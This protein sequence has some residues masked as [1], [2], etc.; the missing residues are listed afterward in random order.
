RWVAALG[1][2]V[3]TSEPIIADG[4][5]F[6]AT[7]DLADG[8]NGGVVAVDLATGAVRWRVLTGKPIRGGVAFAGNVVIT[9]QIDGEV[10][11]LDP[12][13]GT[14]RWRRAMSKGFA[15]QAG[16]VFSPPAVA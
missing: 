13:T 14:I 7:T 8:N 1:N 6:V 4:A 11:A 12:A 9:T 5:V 2:H 10:V 16:A 15:P 3:L